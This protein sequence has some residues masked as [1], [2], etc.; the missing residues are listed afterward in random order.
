[1][2]SSKTISSLIR[3]LAFAMTGPPGNL[4]MVGKTERTLKRNILDPL[5]E[6]LPRSGFKVVEGSG[7]C[8]IFGRRIYL[9]GAND[10]RSGDRI[11]GMT[12]AGAYVDEVSVLPES[13]FTML[14]SRLS[15]D[16]AAVFGTTNPESPRHWLK[17][18]YLDRAGTWLKHDG[19]VVETH[20]GLDMAR[21]SFR[22]SDNPNLSPAYI[23]SLR[24]EYTGL[25]AKRFIEGL[26]V[27]AEGSIWDTF[28]ADVNGP[29]VV[30]VLPEFERFWLA[31]DYGTTNPFVALLIGQS[32][33]ED[34]GMERLYVARE[35]RWDSKVQRRQLTDAEYSTSLRAWLA[36]LGTERLT[37]NYGMSIEPLIDRIYVD[38]SAA[39]FSTQLYRDGWHGVH[40][41]D[42]AVD[43]GIRAVGTLLN[44]DRLKIHESCAGLIGE[45]A[46]YV[47]DTKAQA[48]GID[49]PVKVDDHGPDAMRYGVWS[50]RR[51]WLPWVASMPVQLYADAA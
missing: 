2:R 29:H 42:N 28:D 44:A 21:F 26:W 40:H 25:W 13:F 47:W 10:E 11:R 51:L 20:D 7:E 3:W 24:Q 18:K 27:L 17:V 45:A 1:M 30:S 35:W 9:A 8:F 5:A 50:Q 46:G 34:D 6:L 16:G 23:A 14:L 49:K 41:A 33:A 22:L 48:V 12:L 32:S 15:V 19:T 39:S 4:L 38:P 43:D 36:T 31:I 37:D